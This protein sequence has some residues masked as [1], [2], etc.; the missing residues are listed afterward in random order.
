MLSANT[1]WLVTND[2]KKPMNDPVFRTG[3]RRV[4]QRQP[5]RQQRLRQH[6]RGRQ[7]DRPAAVVGQVRRQVASSASYGYKYNPTKAKKILTAAGYKMGSD[8]YVRNKD[9]SPIKLSSSSVRAAGRTGRPPS[10]RSSRALKT[11]G[12][13]IDSK[14]P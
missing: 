6:R 7:P 11:A 13:N 12:I 14:A 1:A 8:G 5:D 4:D 10:R 2:K 3:A 9:G